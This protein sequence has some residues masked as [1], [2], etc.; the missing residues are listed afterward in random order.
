MVK[1]GPDGVHQ[2]FIF[3]DSVVQRRAAREK[4][5]VVFDNVGQ[6]DK[7]VDAEKIE[8]GPQEMDLALVGT[9]LEK[10]KPVRILG[11][12]RFEPNVKTVGRNELVEIIGMFHSWKQRE[13][14]TDRLFLSNLKQRDM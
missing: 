2:F 13:G 3:L 1:S 6:V 12:R 5:A 8:I 11:E 10:R 4:V 14:Q 7:E 9:L